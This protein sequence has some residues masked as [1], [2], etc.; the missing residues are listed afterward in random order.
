M[1]VKHKILD[2]DNYRIDKVR[3]ILNPF[4]ITRRQIFAKVTGYLW[5]RKIEI[6]ENW[7]GITKYGSHITFNNLA[8]VAKFSTIE[9]AQDCL[10][11]IIN[12]EISYKYKYEIFIDNENSPFEVNSWIPISLD[13]IKDVDRIPEYIRKGLL[14]E[15]NGLE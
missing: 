9:E 15:I 11:Q 13:R 1:I 14:R 5:W 12:P 2:T 10:K 4:Q 6:K 8:D 3:D 7:V